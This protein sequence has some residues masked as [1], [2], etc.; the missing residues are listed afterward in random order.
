MP[1]QEPFEYGDS[2][3]EEVSEVELRDGDRSGD[4]TSRFG[5][6]IFNCSFTGTEQPAN[7]KQNIF[8]YD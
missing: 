5:Q 2:G 4:W 7:T 6:D 1:G 8:D 3:I